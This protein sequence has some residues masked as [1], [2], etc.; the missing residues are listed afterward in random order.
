MRGI[1]SYIKPGTVHRYSHHKEL[2]HILSIPNILNSY[3]DRIRD[4]VTQHKRGIIGI[5][6]LKIGDIILSTS[7]SYME[8]VRYENEFIAPLIIAMVVNA[9]SILI[10]PDDPKKLYRKLLESITG[11]QAAKVIETIRITGGKIQIDYLEEQGYSIPMVKREDISLWEIL[12]KTSEQFIIYRGIVDYNLIGKTSN[13][14]FQENLNGIS[15]NSSIVKGFLE[16][17]M[18][19]I[20]SK[21]RNGIKEAIENNGMEN[22]YG[23][24]LLYKIDQEMKKNNVTTHYALPLILNATFYAMHKGAM[25][26]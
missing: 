18:D 23:I 10:E 19:T 3:I 4:E 2:L 24:K 14:I 16:Y 7:R 17:L 20:D 9:Y 25:P 1:I 8:W 5:T 13:I 12:E 11:E 22:G 21:Y 6:D 26:P 15:L